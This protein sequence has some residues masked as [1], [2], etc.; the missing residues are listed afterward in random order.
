MSHEAGGLILFSLFVSAASD[1][2]LI[3]SLPR[4]QSQICLLV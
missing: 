2:Y 1:M 4:C 3:Y